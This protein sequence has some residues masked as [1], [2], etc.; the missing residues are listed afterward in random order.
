MKIY[1]GGT[2]YLMK[3]HYSINFSQNGEEN[4]YNP[5]NLLF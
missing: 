3:Q 2:K 4:K 1:W 5:F